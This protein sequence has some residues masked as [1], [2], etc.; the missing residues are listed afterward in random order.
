MLN[1]P[2]LQSAF[3]SALI[4]L[5]IKLESDSPVGATGQFK[6]SWDVDTSPTEMGMKGTLKNIDPIG[7][8]KAIGRGPGRMPPFGEGSPLRAWVLSKGMSP[9]ASFAIARKISLVGTERWR[10]QEN[11]IGATRNNEIP[12]EKQ[13]EYLDYVME[14]VRYYLR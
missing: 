9:G 8:W 2:R 5:A 7:R 11:V 3:E 1:N 13:Q 10:K 14:R 4:D 12:P 6:R